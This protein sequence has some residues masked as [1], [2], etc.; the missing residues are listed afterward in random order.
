MEEDL[1]FLRQV[2]DDSAIDYLLV[3]GADARSG[4]VRPVLAVDERDREGALTALIQACEHEPM[5]WRTAVRRVGKSSPI[6][7]VRRRGRD[8]RTPALVSSGSLG[9]RASDRAFVLY[10]ARANPSG[11][12][13]YGEEYGVR[14]EFWVR[15]V[16]DIHLPDDTAMTRTTIPQVEVTPATV[17]HS[18]L[19]WP[20]LAGMWDT[21]S[22]D[23]NFPID[24][25]FSWVDGTDLEW[26]RA[27]AARMQSYVV[28]EGDDHEARFR[29][30]DELKYAMRSVH[31]FAP[32]IRNIVVVTDSPRPDW[33]A[34]HPRVTVLTS[35]E[36]FTDSTVL[37]TYNSHA[38]ESQLHQIRGLSEH[39]LYSNDD[40]FFGREVEP[41]AFFTAGG[42]SRFVE[43]NTR[44]G[45]GEP[46]SFRSGFENAA[47]VNRALLQGKFG[48]TI[49]RHLEH[50][51]APL[52]RSVLNEL[53]SEFPEDFARTARSR[54]RAAT[55][56]SV[57]NS[58]YHYF[59]LATGRAV[60]NDSVRVSYVDTTVSEGIATLDSLLL[61]RDRDFFCL[62]DGSFPELSAEVRAEA[63]RAFLEDYFP[64]PAPW[65]QGSI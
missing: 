23:I 2:F 24:I 27:R 10:R 20:T 46:E 49:S 57:T 7:P 17:E 51:P 15:D 1:R 30:I 22:S 59:A 3:R 4:A 43:S 26:Q 47:R 28:G 32:W 34:E 13:R 36:F 29:Q 64:I 42:I 50:C 40:M 31:L 14:L 55:D 35:A 25:V 18:G 5:Y 60:V 41:Q 37:P 52:R 8:G 54:F 61:R 9:T 53:E 12:L 44:I 19:T 11:T 38:V 16:V 63:V 21:L 65:E 45:L 39:F 48:H 58:L 33:L 6:S 62:N 56:I